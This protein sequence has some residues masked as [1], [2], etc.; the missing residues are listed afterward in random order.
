VEPPGGSRSRTIAPFAD[1]A[2]SPDT[3]LWHWSY[4]RGRK[5]VV[6]DIATEQGRS[7]LLRLVAGA[8]F[9]IES[10]DP[11]TMDSLGLGYDTLGAV[12]P[13]LIM[14]SITPFGS[15][16]PKANWPVTDLTVL[17]AGGQMAMTG[18]DD[19]APLR[20]PLP[21]VYFHACAEGAGGALIALY[22]RQHNSGLGQHVDTSAQESAMQAAQTYM[23]AGPVGASANSRVAGGVKTA[24]INVRLMWPC[25]DGHMSV[26]FL[27]GTALGPFSRRLMEWVHEE[28]FCDE[29]TRDKD[30]NNYA[31]LLFGGVEPVEEYER[32]KQAIED[33]MLTKT[34]KEL[35]EAA[36][37][38]RLLFAPVTTAE[39]VLDSPHLAAREMW[40]DVTIGGREV[41]FPGR[42]ALFSETP[43]PT[44]GQPPA[45]GQHTVEVLS[46][47]PRRPVVPIE[48]VP[49][50]TGKALEG[51]KILDF[52]WVMAGPAGSRVLAD[53]GANIVRIDS[54]ARMD[55]ARTL[56][57]FR[58]DEGLPD[59]SSLYN[60]MNAGKRGLSL[61][62]T[63]P[64]ARDV[65]HDLVRWSDVVLE[66]F[67]PKA[68]KGFGFDYESLRQVK[69]DLVMLSSCI[70]GQTGPWTSLAGFGTMAAAISGFFDI[71]GWPDRAPSGPFGAYTDYISPRYLV[72]CVMAAV[73]HHRATG[74]GQYIDFSQGEASLQQ[75][76]PVLLDWT[77][78]R[79]LWERRANR[80]PI[81]APHGVFRS[82]GDDQWVAIAVTT[83]EQ[84]RALCELMGASGV[85][86]LDADARQT[87]VD[88][89]EQLVES[90][91]SARSN[92][93]VMDACIAA[94]IPAH[95]V[96]NTNECFAD[97]QLVHRNHFVEVEHATQGTTWVE[98]TRM[99]FSRTPAV[100]T[101]GGPTW[102]EHNWEILTEELGY[103]PERIA[104]LAVAEV[105]G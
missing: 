86:D 58:D 37:E 3:S 103:D 64:E 102:G 68:M 6:L 105:L 23:L 66:S 27:F 5:S 25:K 45:I 13:A 63:K 60:S 59:N 85:A 96:Q 14:V 57:P 72:S 2:A 54:E 62:L 89:L 28:G 97:P 4:N 84:W 41:R 32:V 47:P 83:D 88:E 93:E 104:D 67:S 46:E 61:D 53:Y 31:E 17:A 99:H 95:Q 76:T 100:V 65:V 1:D 7:D 50:R 12:N 87:R 40:E 33:F 26:T 49:G 43:Q 29:A 10:F 77:V 56:G 42:M 55:T 24:G 38:R 71:T 22:E 80:D 20:I 21:Q 82:A 9:L 48:P 19:R 16:G 34:K 18:D 30:W 73:E 74:Q 94:G 51:L 81:Y 70:M 44:L 91:T 36:F 90:W 69:P 98:N 79:R 8:D 52:M 35:F 11:G 15:T 39:D 101:H 78:N 92:T 75:L